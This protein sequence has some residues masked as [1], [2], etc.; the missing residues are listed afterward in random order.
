MTARPRYI[1]NQLPLPTDLGESEFEQWVR[2]QAWKRGWC[3]YHVR[4][5]EG[6]VQGVH[7]LVEGHEDAMGF[8]DWCFA[9]DGVVLI[10][11]LKTNRGIVSRH[12]KHWL[13]VLGLTERGVWRPRDAERVLEELT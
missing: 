13:R 3:G 2:Y 1:P 5:S 9:R 7:R 4:N 11:E 6:V 8:P 12:Q 10:R